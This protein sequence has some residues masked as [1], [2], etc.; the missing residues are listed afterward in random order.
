MLSPLVPAPGVHGLGSAPKAPGSIFPSSWCFS[1]ILTICSGSR[2]YA[3]GS[4]MLWQC[5]CLC[6]LCWFVCNSS[7]TLW[8]HVLFAMYRVW[9]LYLCGFDTCCGAAEAAVCVCLSA[10]TSDCV[11][12]CAALMGAAPYGYQRSSCTVF[13]TPV[14]D[15]C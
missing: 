9:W 15:V 2:V 8:Q 1:K 10:Y 5:V 11:L 7:G 14:F 12:V 3:D 4:R 6:V 13:G